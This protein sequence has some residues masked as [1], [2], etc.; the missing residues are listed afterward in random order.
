MLGVCLEIAASAFTWQHFNNSESRR[1]VLSYTQT[2]LGMRH[3]INTPRYLFI[4]RIPTLRY[5]TASF[6]CRAATDALERCRAHAEKSADRTSSAVDAWLAE[7][8]RRWEAGRTRCEE[9]A[10]PPG[11]A[12]IEGAPEEDVAGVANVTAGL[13]VTP[14]LIGAGGDSRSRTGGSGDGSCVAEGLQGTWKR[15]S[16][17]DWGKGFGK[18]VSFDDFFQT[19][20]GGEEVVGQRGHG[21]PI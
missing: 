7:R 1:S 15:P 21:T 3:T 4:E 11:G 6:R 17:W 9:L 10:P 14:A 19:F 18:G 20:A 2:Q 5:P 13:I 12:R 8:R 16:S